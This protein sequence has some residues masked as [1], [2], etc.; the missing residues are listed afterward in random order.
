MANAD[1]VQ[2]ILEARNELSQEI[3]KAEKDLKSLKAREAAMVKDVVA[4]NVL[5]KNSYDEVHDEVVQLEASISRLREKRKMLAAQERAE[6]RKAVQDELEIRE[7]I[8]RR[9]AAIVS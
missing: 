2:I 6:A 3:R 1:R 9:E 4:G 5:V 8:K 7:G